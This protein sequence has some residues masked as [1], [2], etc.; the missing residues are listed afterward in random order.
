MVEDQ[1]RKFSFIF[2]KMWLVFGKLSGVPFF[3]RGTTR[4][5]LEFR[6]HTGTVQKFEDSL[7]H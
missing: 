3:K 5:G 2:T 1:K 6:N 4:M 7:G